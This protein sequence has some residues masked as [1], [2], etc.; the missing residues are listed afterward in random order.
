MAADPKPN[1]RRLVLLLWLLVAVYYF[2]LTFDYIR[3]EVND[4][5]FGDYVRYVT[6]LAANENRS[7]REVRALL[8]VRADELGV[9]LSSDQIKIQGSGHEL[10]VLLQYDVDID[11]PILS[12]GFYS[13]HYV[14]TASYR[15]PR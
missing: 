12:S 7:P 6:Q 8:L 10:K 13:K 2:Y 4:D 5:K 3:V 9:P 15:H 11:V 1:A 14:H